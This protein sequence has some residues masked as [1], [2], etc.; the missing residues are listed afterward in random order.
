MAEISA[1]A[2]STHVLHLDV[3]FHIIAWFQSAAAAH[4]LLVEK[5]LL[6][7]VRSFDGSIPVFQRTYDSLI[8]HRMGGVFQSHVSRA[9]ISPANKYSSISRRIFANWRR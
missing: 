9:Q 8:F 5:Y 6:H 4:V 2:L 1:K 7:D 3:E